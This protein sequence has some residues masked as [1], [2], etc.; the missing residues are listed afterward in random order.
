MN[1]YVLAAD[2]LLII[3]TL[4]V[5]FV[6]AG[7]VLIIIG[8]IRHWAWVRNPRF[9]AAHLCAIG[10]VVLQAWAGRICPLTIWEMDLRERGGQATYD[11]SFIAYWL[12][13]LLYYD[14]SPWVFVTLYSGFG[15]LVLASWWWI[16]PRSFR[17]G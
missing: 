2:A 9:R 12:G 5:V 7:L 16:R 1:G 10:V 13:R 3:H 11:E 4:F 14:A 17:S 8:G 6:V 15:L